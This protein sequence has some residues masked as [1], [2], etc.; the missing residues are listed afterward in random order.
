MTAMM[1]FAVAPALPRF[2]YAIFFSLSVVIA[3]GSAVFYFLTHRWTLDRR[4]AALADW[5]AEKRFHLQLPPRTQLPAALQSLASLGARV[6]LAFIR[7]PISILQLTTIAQPGSRELRWHVLLREM[8]RAWAPA[9]LRPVNPAPS[10]LDLFA[11]NGF[12]SLL[13][14]ERFAVFATDTNSA[15]AM[16]KSPVRGL[17][18]P[19]IGLLVHGPYVTLDFSRRPFDTIEFERMLVIMEQLVTHLPAQAESHPV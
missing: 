18:P 15:R 13:P 5:A 14:P 4:R 9:G 1:P 16:A 12:P 2:N 6:D 8:D 3:A 7:G 11:L 10:F 17:L 19:D